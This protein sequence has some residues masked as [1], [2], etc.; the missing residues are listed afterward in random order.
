MDTTRDFLAALK[1]RHGLRTDGDLH[2]LLGISRARISRYQKGQDYFGDDIAVKVAAELDIDPGYVLACVG[3]E[4]ARSA[5]ARAE[6]AALAKKLSPAAAAMLLASGALLT[7]ALPS[8]DAL[9]AFAAVI[10]ADTLYIMLNLL[11]AALAVL[12]LWP[13]QRNNP[14]RPRGSPLLRIS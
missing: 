2:R 5:T 7:G 4:R 1:R 12:S 9:T 14:H 11:A 6:W 10:P 3:A 13:R 8:P